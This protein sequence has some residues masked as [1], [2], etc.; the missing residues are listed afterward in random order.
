MSNQIQIDLSKAYAGQIVMYR[1]K[2]NAVIGTIYLS[3]FTNYYSIHSVCGSFHTLH[4]KDGTDLDNETPFDIIALFDPIQVQCAR[5]EGEIKGL[6]DS[7]N[8]KVYLDD[9][10]ILAAIYRLNEQLKA[11]TN[12]GNN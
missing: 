1:S 4:R 6:Q 5:I 9:S 11:L 10:D 2:Q 3:D 8:C 12:E 7:M